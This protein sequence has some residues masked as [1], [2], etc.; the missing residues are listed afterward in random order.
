MFVK[1]K[2][3]FKTFLNLNEFEIFLKYFVTSSILLKKKYI[4]YQNSFDNVSNEIFL[5]NKTSAFTF[6]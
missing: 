5:L 4:E 1:W 3:T 2:L 6:M